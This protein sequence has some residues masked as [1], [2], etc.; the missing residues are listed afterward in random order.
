M[1]AV[2]GA[3]VGWESVGFGVVGW[4]LGDFFSVVGLSGVRSVVD[5]GVDDSA[6]SVDD[7]ALSV[8][9]LSCDFSVVG[10]GADESALS[11]VGWGAD[12]SA[13]SVVGLSGHFSMVDRLVAFSS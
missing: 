9:R 5:W 4:V 1:G 3:V 2:G 8:V 13:L 7:S 11:V 10:W 6:L 12:D